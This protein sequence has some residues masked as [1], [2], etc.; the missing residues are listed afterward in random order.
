[1][2]SL[3]DLSLGRVSRSVRRDL[4]SRIG[5][6]LDLRRSRARLAQLD[7]RMLDD[8]GLDRSTA[9]AEANRPIWDA[10]SFWTK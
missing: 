7:A 4:L 10:P 3:M 5:H 1:M 9:E 6:A 2:S 8:I